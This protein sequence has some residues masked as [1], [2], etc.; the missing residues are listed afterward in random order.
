MTVIG[1]CFIFP[2]VCNISKRD[3]LLE[4]FKV[5]VRYNYDY[6]DPIIGKM[7]ITAHQDQ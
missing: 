3:F 2:L 6:K 7:I 1:V 5:R 4:T